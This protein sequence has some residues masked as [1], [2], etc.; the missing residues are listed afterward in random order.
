MYYFLIVPFNLKNDSTCRNQT[1]TKWLTNHIVLHG[2]LH[3]F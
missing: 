2:F 1:N 3:R